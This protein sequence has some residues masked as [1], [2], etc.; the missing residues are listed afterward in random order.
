MSLMGSL[1]FSLGRCARG[2][3]LH[4]RKYRAVYKDFIKFPVRVGARRAK[5]GK[6][7]SSIDPQLQNKP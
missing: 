5:G 2:R 1:L 6:F 4:M 7:Q 3:K